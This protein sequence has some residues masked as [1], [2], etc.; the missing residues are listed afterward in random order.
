MNLGTLQYKII[1]MIKPYPIGRQDF[2]S[3]IQEGYTYV[4][5][6]EIMHCMIQN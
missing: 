2:R 5:K 6:T 3:I 1:A 4:D